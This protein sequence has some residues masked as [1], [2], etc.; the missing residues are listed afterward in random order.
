[1]IHRVVIGLMVAFSS[2]AH[3]AWAADRPAAS[4]NVSDIQAK[5]NEINSSGAD[6]DRVLVPAGTC[7]WTGGIGTGLSPKAMTILGAG[8][9]PDVGAPT[10]GGTIININ[11]SGFDTVDLHPS[12]TGNVVLAG[13]TFV[14]GSA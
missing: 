5:I 6:G 10:S 4:C 8:T 14:V 3:A 13:F 11:M 1:M 12:S 9:L 2:L 7:T